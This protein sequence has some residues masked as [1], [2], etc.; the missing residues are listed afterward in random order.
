MIKT[1]WKWSVPFL[2]I[3]VAL[4]NSEF[5][6]FLFGDTINRNVTNAGFFSASIFKTGDSKLRNQQ[7]G[8]NSIVAVE[9]VAVKDPF[10]P[11]K[12]GTGLNRKIPQ[13]PLQGIELQ[14]DRSYAV[15]SGRRLSIGDKIFGMRIINICNNKVV[16]AGKGRARVYYLF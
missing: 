4:L 9:K 11:P 13:N 12:F 7:I 16:L 3:N 8:I 15:I 1:F 10:H 14:K 6:Q 2:I 5:R